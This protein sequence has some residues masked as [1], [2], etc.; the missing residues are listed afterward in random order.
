MLTNP[1]GKGTD[2]HGRLKDTFLTTPHVMVDDFCHIYSPKRRHQ[3]LKPPSSES[4]VITLASS[5]VGVA[6]LA[7]GTSTPLRSKPPAR[8]LPKPLPDRSQFNR[9]MRR[10]CVGLIE[11]VGLC[12]WR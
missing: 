11:E 12:T 8:R 6:S 10:S 7:S 3:A 5:L 4:E 9:L 2:S 1:E